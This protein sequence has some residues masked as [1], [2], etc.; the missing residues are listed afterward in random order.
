M[1]GVLFPLAIVVMLLGLAINVAMVLKGSHHIV[2]AL[3]LAVALRSKNAADD[4]RW[5]DSD[6][7]PDDD[8]VGAPSLSSYHH[9]NADWAYE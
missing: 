7:D 2:K 1:F 6:P 8:G 4:A 3:G 5:D 9:S